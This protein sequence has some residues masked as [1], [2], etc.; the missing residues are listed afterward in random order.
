MKYLHI[1]YILS[2]VVLASLVIY[3]LLKPQ[4][5]P[6]VTTR[7]IPTVTINEQPDTLAPIETGLTRDEVSQM[8]DDA[9]SALPIPTPQVVEKVVEK[10]TE[11]QTSGDK[12][13]T[14]VPLGTSGST[15][16]TDWVTFDDTG[17][18]IDV[19]SDYGD[20]A[21]IQFE[22]SL[23]AMSGSGTS[24]ARLYDDT[25]KIGVIGSEL[26]VAES[27]TYTLKLSPKL[28]LWRGRNLYKVQLKSLSGST[29]Q[30]TGARV[31][32]SY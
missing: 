9:I 14:Y 8:I 12:S 26:S 30:F 13:T 27:S 31:K 4:A 29:A 32:V 16:S 5:K 6:A 11:V 1:F 20:D 7:N 22:I 2:I 3:L 15:N 17:A 10:T 18:Y 25:N 28:E 21:Y 19:V 24:I 23:K